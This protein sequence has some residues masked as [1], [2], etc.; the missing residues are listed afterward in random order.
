MPSSTGQRMTTPQPRQNPDRHR[1]DQAWQ[2]GISEKA[3]QAQILQLAR[4]HG[5]HSYHTYDSRRSV[6][7][8]PD[9]TLVRGFR[10]IFAEIKTQKGRVQPAQQEGLDRLGFAGCETYVWRP[11]DLSV[12]V[13][14]LSRPR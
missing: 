9:L 2:N 4:M 1:W 12:V 7:G 5:W 3:W 14:C 8:Y 10:L 13:E 11:S 6:A